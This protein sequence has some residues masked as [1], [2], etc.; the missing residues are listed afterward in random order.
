M[1]EKTQEL[2]RIKKNSLHLPI[3]SSLQEAQKKEQRVRKQK[4]WAALPSV[5]FQTWSLTTDTSTNGQASTSESTTVWF[6][7]NLWS[8]LLRPQQLQTFVSG[9]RSVERKKIT[10]SQREPQKLNHLALKRVLKSHQTLSPAGLASTCSLIGYAP[11][12]QTPSGH[13]FQTWSRMT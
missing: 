2:P 11:R 7:K 10:S 4:L 3:N 6:S 9:E 8:N 13:H 12:Q 1:L 5:S